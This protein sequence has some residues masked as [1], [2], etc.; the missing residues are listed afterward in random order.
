MIR[1]GITSRDGWVMAH[2]LT[3]VLE[4]RAKELE[5]LSEDRIKGLVYSVIG[6]FVLSNG[7]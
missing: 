3:K 5:S 1:E 2:L 7:K 4:V 6:A